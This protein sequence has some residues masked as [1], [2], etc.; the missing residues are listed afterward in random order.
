VWP[1]QTRLDYGESPAFS[2]KPFVFAGRG[3]LSGPSPAR[4]GITAAEILPQ[5]RRQALG[6]ARLARRPRRRLLALAACHAFPLERNPAKW[7][8]VRRKIAR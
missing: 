8:P 1:L 2:L 6:P 3:L 7:E 4:L 5:R